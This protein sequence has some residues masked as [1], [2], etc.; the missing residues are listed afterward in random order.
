MA[1]FKSA[2]L[3]CCDVSTKHGKQELRVASGYIYPRTVARLDLSPAPGRSGF[4]SRF[5]GPAV[6]CCELFPSAKLDGV[7]DPSAKT[8]DAKHSRLHLKWNRGSFQYCIPTPY[9][10]AATSSRAHIIS[11]L[12]RSI[13]PESRLA[14]RSFLNQRLSIMSIATQSQSPTITADDLDEADSTLGDDLQ[15]SRTQ[16][17]RSSLLECVQENGRGYHRYKSTLEYPLPED[18]GEQDRL[19]L[20]HETFLRTF[21]GKLFL[22]PLGKDVR[23]VLDLGTGTGIW[24][25]SCNLP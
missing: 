5:P 23:H 17:L 3:Q 11:H 4:L 12:S 6:Y 10:F 9:F 1:K 21:N 20:Q 16:S 15:P 22:S 7:L 18:E 13:Y 25:C 14:R 19:D 24:V 2:L 8:R